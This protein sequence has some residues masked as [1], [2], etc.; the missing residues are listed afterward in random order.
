MRLGTK[1]RTFQ[2][3][4]SLEKNEAHQRGSNVTNALHRKHSRNHAT[5]GSFLLSG[6]LRCDRCAERIL[7]S[8]A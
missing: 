5:A 1:F 3:M 4:D 6:L 7:A 2:I 8:D